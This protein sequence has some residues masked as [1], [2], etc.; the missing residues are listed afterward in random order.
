MKESPNLPPRLPLRFFR[1]FCDPQIRDCIEGDLI[2]LHNDRVKKIGSRKA[3]LRFLQD[4]LLLFRP[5][6]IRP[7]GL[8]PNLNQSAMYR[9][10][11][12]IGFRNIL[13]YKTF[14]FINI[15]GLA[16][17]M[18]VSMLILM[19]LA[20]QNRY[21]QFHEKKDRIYRILSDY[22][23]SKNQYATSPP[24]LAAELAEYP[25]V[26]TTTQL[27]PA[28]GGD[29]TFEEKSKGIDGHFADQGF[30]NVFSFELEA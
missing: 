21:D 22:E 14:S 4:V 9:N 19:M 10:Y 7:L 5:G 11:F 20:E 12:K 24:P 30:F 17:A 3:N 28:V 23:G 8:S 29:V 26:E 16:L 18:S 25:A 27:V 15:F 6:I 2:E 13:K 1:S